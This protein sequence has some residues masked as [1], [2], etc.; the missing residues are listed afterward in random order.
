MRRR[1]LIR[2]PLSLALAS[3]LACKGHLLSS[4][5]FIVK[6]PEFINWGR[7]LPIRNTTFLNICAYHFP[8]ETFIVSTFAQ[9]EFIAKPYGV[10][11][12]RCLLNAAGFTPAPEDATHHLPLI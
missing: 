6:K 7:Y 10:T 1:G 11:G 2:P 8:S 5:R 3:M 4:Q 9:T 12:L